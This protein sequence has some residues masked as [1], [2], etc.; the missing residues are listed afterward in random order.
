MLGLGKL[1]SEE[2]NYSSDVDLIY[3]FE[4]PPFAEGVGGGPGGLAPAE[5]FT[6]VAQ[7]FGRW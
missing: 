1:G 3:V 5:Y 6:R 2:L 7:E 4:S